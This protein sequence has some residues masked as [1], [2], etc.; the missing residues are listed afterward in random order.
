MAM[1]KSILHLVKVMG[2]L[3]GMMTK[4]PKNL[5]NIMR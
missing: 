2:G 5:R 4:S 3:A 1:R